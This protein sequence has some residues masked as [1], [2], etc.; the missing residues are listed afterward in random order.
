[1]K[2]VFSPYIALV[3][4]T[5]LHHQFLAPVCLNLRLATKD[6]IER[7]EILS[8]VFFLSA[9]ALGLSNGAKADVILRG[10]NPAD[11]LPMDIGFKQGKCCV[12]SHT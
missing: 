12:I 7:K 6:H 9:E 2:E 5:H 4:A 3:N 1:M 10:K 11:R 8:S